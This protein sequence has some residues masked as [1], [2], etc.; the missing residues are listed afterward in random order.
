MHVHKCAYFLATL[1]F[2]KYFLSFFLYF[3]LLCSGITAF[4]ISN[5]MA[6]LKV[7]FATFIEKPVKNLSKLNKHT[8]SYSLVVLR[9][10][11][12]TDFFF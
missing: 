1:D 3:L 12:S 5:L 9:F 11:K 10:Y 2:L 4:F 8:N 6:I 7:P